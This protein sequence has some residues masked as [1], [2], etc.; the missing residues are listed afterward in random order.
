TRG[1]RA[2]EEPRILGRPPPH[3]GQWKSAA[4]FL[5]AV[6][7]DLLA[8][9][10]EPGRRRQTRRPG[11]GDAAEA[12]ADDGARVMG[13]AAVALAL[14]GTRD[15]R[16]DDRRAGQRGSRVRGLGGGEAAVAERGDRADDPRPDPADDGVE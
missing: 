13:D 5:P 7:L 8:R 10:G 15:A 9:L 11:D 3:M 1:K 14:V 12:E 2:G 6:D 16:G 4:R